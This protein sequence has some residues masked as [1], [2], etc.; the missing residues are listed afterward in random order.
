MTEAEFV[1]LIRSYPEEFL[2][3]SAPLVT[4]A[5][6]M[7]NMTAI[8]PVTR[9]LPQ[10]ERDTLQQHME[11]MAASALT[12]AKDPAAFYQSIHPG[13]RDRF[14]QTIQK[15]FATYSRTRSRANN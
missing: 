7:A 12:M 14:I 5:I 9:F 11:T 4:L 10:E 3:L 2:K 1:T 13:V 6:R 15:G 8:C